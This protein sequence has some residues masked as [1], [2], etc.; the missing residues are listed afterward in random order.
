MR[1][2][3]PL[4][5]VVALVALWVNSAVRAARQHGMPVPWGRVATF[6]GVLLGMGWLT[7]VLLRHR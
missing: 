2:F 3:G 5:V 4:I 1:D 7:V 6:S